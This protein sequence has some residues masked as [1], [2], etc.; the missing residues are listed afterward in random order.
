MAAEFFSRVPFSAALSFSSRVKYDSNFFRLGWLFWWGFACDMRDMMGEGEFNVQPFPDSAGRH[1]PCP[2]CRVILLCRPYPPH[3][4]HHLPVPHQQTSSHH[5]CHCPP[6]S[7]SSRPKCPCP[8]LTACIEESVAPPFPPPPRTK[9]NRV[10]AHVCRAFSFS[11]SISSHVMTQK[12]QRATMYYVQHIIPTCTLR[13]AKAETKGKSAP[14]REKDLSLCPCCFV[15]F[16][17]L[18]LRAMV[19]ERRPG[20]D[21]RRDLSD[22]QPRTF[23]PPDKKRAR[24]KNRQERTW[25]VT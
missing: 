17:T 4:P 20:S 23:L 1:A 6:S 9:P 19:S 11:I 8:P 16:L 7:P 13:R 24:G 12:A 25:A 14:H 10:A 5:N 21:R 18:L 2:F 15:F 3:I 22:R